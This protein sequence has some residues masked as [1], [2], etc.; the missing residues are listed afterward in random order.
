[1][2]NPTHTKCYTEPCAD[3][4]FSMGSYEKNEKS[5][6]NSY[7]SHDIKLS[8]QPFF[9]KSHTKQR[10]TNY[11]MENLEDLDEDESAECQE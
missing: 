1:M 8:G 2:R 7:G 5:E 4:L 10:S 3:E 9:P 11:Y 6:K